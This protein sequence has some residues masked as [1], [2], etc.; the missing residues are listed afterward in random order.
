MSAIRSVPND[1][2]NNKHNNNDAAPAGPS[3]PSSSSSSFSSSSPPSVVASGLKS[4]SMD[5]YLDALNR[6]WEEGAA[7][8]AIE[9]LTELRGLVAPVA[10]PAIFYHQAIGACARVGYGRGASEVLAAM[11]SDGVAVLTQESVS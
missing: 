4:Y 11:R 10:P 5:A 2:D 6:C 9:M 8:E 7:M 3:P 1:D